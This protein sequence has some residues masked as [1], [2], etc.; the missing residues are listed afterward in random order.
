MQKKN[1]RRRKNAKIKLPLWLGVFLTLL[2]AAAALLRTQPWAQTDEKTTPTAAMPDGTLCV[3]FLDVGQGD[4]ILLG[5]D[6]AYMLVDGGSVSQSQFL[7]SRLN[8]LEVKSLDYV[9]NTHPDEDHCGGLAGVLARYPAQHVYA[10]VTEHTTRAFENVAKYADAQ[11]SSIEM[12]ELG[13]SWQLGEAT[14]ELI[15]PVEDFDETNNQSL[16]LRVDYGQTSFLL[17]G[18]MEVEAEEALLRAG[19][20]V[21]ADILK[22]GHHGSTTS[23]S[24]AFLNAVSPSIA[25]ISAGE[26]NDYGHPHEQTLTALQT[27][28][29]ELYRTDTQ[30]EIIMISDG[31]TITVTT[32]PTSREAPTTAAAYVGNVNSRIVHSANCAKLPGEKNRVPFDELEQ[33]LAL[34]YE[35]H[36]CIPD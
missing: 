28:Q 6:G 13:T 15:G 20:N 29:I 36:S 1:K 19:A 5:C 24:Q 35:K 12:P 7:V 27:R 30:G 3:R 11:G 21:R 17:T 16:I 34:G 26:G 4:S 18:D 8:R 23:T 10:S 14:V 33:A 25:V 32:D 22:V 31:E 2:C 9:V